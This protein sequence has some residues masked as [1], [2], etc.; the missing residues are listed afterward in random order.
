MKNSLITGDDR[1][2]SD[3]QGF[4]D[5]VAILI[6]KC[7]E[8]SMDADQDVYDWFFLIENWQLEI[9]GQLT[10]RGLSKELDEVKILRKSTREKL[11]KAYV[12][13]GGRVGNLPPRDVSALRNIVYPYHELMSIV[14]HKMDLR[15]HEVK[16]KA[17]DEPTWSNN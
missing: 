3:D 4:L 9:I 5:T 14:T 10:L 6:N 7:H 11:D 17:N 1:T 8:A 16:V 12:K 13:I 15:L 2:W